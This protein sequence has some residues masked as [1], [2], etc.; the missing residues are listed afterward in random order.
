M[1]QLR[2][3]ISEDNATHTLHIQKSLTLEGIQ[4]S[5]HI[6]KFRGGR[7]VLKVLEYYFIPTHVVDSIA[8]DVLY[9]NIL[10]GV[11]S[12]HCLVAKKR[13]L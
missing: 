10:R 8:S 2:Y 4:D 13:L 12:Q 9:A 1:N 6:T 7:A 3:I 11:I 5:T